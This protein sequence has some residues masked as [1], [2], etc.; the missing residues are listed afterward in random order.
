MK[1]IED[2]ANRVKEVTG[3]DYKTAEFLGV[4]RQTISGWRGRRS[5]PTNRHVLKLCAHCNID[6]REALEAI[7]FSRENERPLKQAGF[8]DVGLVGWLGMGTFAAMSL[9][10]MTHLPYEAIGAAIIGLNCVYYVKW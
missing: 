7:E 6:V 9:D 3:S 8:A 4:E 1:N 5:F 2:F 10:K